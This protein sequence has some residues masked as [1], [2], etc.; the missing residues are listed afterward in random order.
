MD[1]TNLIDYLKIADKY[2]EDEKNRIEKIMK[3][4]IGT[5][6]IK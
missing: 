3:W 6:V 2:Y 4:N 1:S 5:N